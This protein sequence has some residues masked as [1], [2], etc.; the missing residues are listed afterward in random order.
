[1]K[2]LDG[3]LYG[4]AWDHVLSSCSLLGFL[5]N[6]FLN[7]FVLEKSNSEL[8][9]VKS[10]QFAFCAMLEIS[11][12]EILKPLGLHLKLAKYCY[13]SSRKYKYE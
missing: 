12:F 4:W 3:G 2:D 8:Q 1:M 6:V 11:L 7:Q 10:P 9:Y 5:K 13:R